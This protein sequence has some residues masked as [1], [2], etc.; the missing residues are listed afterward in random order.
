ML[1]DL[2]VSKTGTITTGELK[3]KRFHFINEAKPKD[4]FPAQI[5]FFMDEVKIIK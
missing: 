1:H 2:C 4:N 5:C 3:V